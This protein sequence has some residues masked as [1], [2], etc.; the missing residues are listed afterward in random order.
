[1]EN[2]KP[3]GRPVK[4]YERPDASKKSSR[5][6]GRPDTR[7]GKSFL[8]DNNKE[9]ELI[10]LNRFFANSGVCSRRDAD[11]HIKNGLISVNGSV[12]TDL[13]TKVTYK[14]EV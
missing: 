6:G 5:P 10:R 4:K 8:K 14:D 13:G 3:A 1:M 2:R 9:I 12:V 11:E 7:P